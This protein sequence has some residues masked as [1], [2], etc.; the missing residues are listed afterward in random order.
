MSSADNSIGPTFRALT[1]QKIRPAE[2]ISAI[3]AAM[4]AFRV[5]VKTISFPDY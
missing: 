2:K 4:R 1:C 5:E 3:A